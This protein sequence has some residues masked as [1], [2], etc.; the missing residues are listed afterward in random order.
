[1]A[2]E[3]IIGP[4]E[5]LTQGYRETFMVIDVGPPDVHD[6]GT[7]CMKHLHSK[8]LADAGKTSDLE[9]SVYLPP[10]YATSR[11]AYPVLYVLHGAGR[12]NRRYFGA[13]LH[14]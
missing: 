8:I 13:P 14:R 6:Q 1:L 5:Y 12:D 10:G 4:A 11:T 9:L 7:R 2:E 3:I